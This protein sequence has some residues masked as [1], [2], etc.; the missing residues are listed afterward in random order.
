MG[1][2]IDL[3]HTREKVRAAIAGRL[4]GV[5]THPDPI[6]GL[7]VPESVP[8]VPDGILEPRE[9]WP[10]K[11]AY[12]EQA[13]NRAGILKENFEMFAGEVEEEVRRAGP[14]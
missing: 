12:D 11:N 4:D 5:E 3:P 8:G 13:K 9:T 10:D 14:Q 2:R 6:F 1:E 7:N